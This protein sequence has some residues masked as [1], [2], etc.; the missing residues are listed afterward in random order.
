[1]N[2]ISLQSNRP[3]YELPRRESYDY[4]A[5]RCSS[6][7]VRWVYHPFLVRV[8]IRYRCAGG[9]AVI[10]TY[11]CTKYRLHWPFSVFGGLL[12]VVGC[13]ASYSALVPDAVLI[14]L[15]RWDL[16]RYGE[17]RICFCRQVSLRGLLPEHDGRLRGFFSRSVG[18][19]RF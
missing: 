1:M 4:T 17:A 2:C 8:I 7:R 13:E 6:L 16:G 10:I 15:L 11:L 9:V 5:A 12:T 19:G 14:D 18:Y 3:L